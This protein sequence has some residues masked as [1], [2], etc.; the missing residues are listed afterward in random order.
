VSRIPLITERDELAGDG[1]VVFD[2]IVESRGTILRPFEVLL[3]SPAIA[4]RVAALGHVI[5]S[6]SRL[7][8]ADRELITLA[9]GR[10]QGCAFVWESHVTAAREAGIASG[11][12]AALEGGGPGLGPREGTL[13]SFV[14]ELCGTGSVSDATFRVAHDLLGTTAVVEMAL[15]VGYYTMLGYT[16]GA[17][18]AC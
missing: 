15:T 13:V 5:R 8:V 1:R 2:R 18:E 4:D 3:H 12:I 6:G 17:V 7:T 16:M 14:N 10:A 11:T 9:T